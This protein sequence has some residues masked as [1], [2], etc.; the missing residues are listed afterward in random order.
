MKRICFG[1]KQI[2]GWLQESWGSCSSGPGSFL[3]LWLNHASER[4]SEDSF[5][6]KFLKLSDYSQWL[7][8]IQN[9]ADLTFISFYWPKAFLKITVDWQIKTHSLFPNWDWEGICGRG[10]SSWEECEEALLVYFSVLMRHFLGKGEGVPGKYDLLLHGPPFFLQ[11]CWVPGRAFSVN[12]GLDNRPEVYLFCTMGW[13]RE[14]GHPNPRSKWAL[15]FLFSQERG[16]VNL[17]TGVT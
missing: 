4:S 2:L 10:C 9:N 14:Q 16:W 8:E 15:V 12:V 3:V 5:C 11:A 1:E 13:R 7:V 17:Q 6:N